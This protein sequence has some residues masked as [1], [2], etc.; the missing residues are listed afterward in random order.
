MSSPPKKILLTGATGY[1]GGSILSTLIS[2]PHASIQNS[3]I[4]C[5]VRG[6]DRADA[7]TVT[8]AGRVTPVLFK[9]LDD[10]D[11][12][13]QVASQH[14]IIINTLLGYHPSSAAALVRGLGERRKQTGQDVF[15]IHTSGTSNL[16][17]R[18]ISAKY[19]ESRV[20][21]D[22][23]TDIYS[24]EKRRNAAQPYGQRSSELGVIDTGLDTGVKTLVIMSPTI[25][26]I[27]TGAFNKLTIQVPTYIRATLSA[28]RAVVI[29]DGKGVWDH[30][31]IADLAQLYELVLA[32]MLA[33]GEDLA[34]GERGIV[35]S[36]NGEHTWGEVARGVADAAVQLGKVKTAEVRSIGLDEGAAV[37]AGG[38]ELLAEL[39]FSS[40]SRTR[41]DLARAWGWKPTRG[42]EDWKRSFVD[43]M[44]AV[45]EQ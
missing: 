3:S 33:G 37:F 43:E 32:K 44:R 19:A 40:N 24:Y 34:F 14:D 13:I 30:V 6:Q 42:E 12:V 9:D 17:D 10:T 4:T 25:F 15:M 45:L 27:G 41:S 22:T 23:D 29:G 16:A 31:H 26:G 36:A 7:L 8:H 2:S 38:D 11:R 5:L 28:G 1:I 39:G 18:P 21:S 35:F 20:F